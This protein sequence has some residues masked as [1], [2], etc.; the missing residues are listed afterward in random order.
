MSSVAKLIATGAFVAGIA[1]PAAAQY[2]PYPVDT[3]SYPQD[4][5][6]YPQDEQSYP[7]YEPQYPSESDNPQE[8]EQYPQYQQPYSYPQ[9]PQNYPGY[10]YGQTYND[11]V[12]AIVDQLLGRGYSVSDR[13]AVRQCA[14]AAIA[15][16][17]GQFG[18][19]AG[20]YSRDEQ[21][22][23]YGSSLRLTAITSVERRSDGLEV[24]GELSTGDELYGGE[25]NQAYNPGDLSFRCNVDYR[26]VVTDV[27]LRQGSDEGY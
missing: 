11:P 25:Y 4:T 9:Y 7:Q 8:E 15:Q 16:A 20:D 14:T 17:Q 2:Q 13:S 21:Y 27:R 26:G 1:A 6:Q 10:G 3:Q 23:S 12:G 22:G 18:G 24:R 5:Q 19:G